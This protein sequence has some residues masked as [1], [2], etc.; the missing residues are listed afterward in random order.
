MRLQF[1]GRGDSVIGKTIVKGILEKY[2]NM[3]K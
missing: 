1:L 3:K 2:E